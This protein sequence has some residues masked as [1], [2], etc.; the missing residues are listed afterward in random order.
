MHVSFFLFSPD[1]N[2]VV[3]FCPS[4][5]ISKVVECSGAFKRS[6]L[7]RKFELS[8]ASVLELCSTDVESFVL[9]E[10]SYSVDFALQF[11]K[12]WNRIFVG[13]EFCNTFVLI[14]DS[15]FCLSVKKSLQRNQSELSFKPTV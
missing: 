10:S 14:R 1:S 13:R 5:A 4:F 3:Y 6:T 8:C 2:D 11:G 9:I 7:S 12:A 15:G